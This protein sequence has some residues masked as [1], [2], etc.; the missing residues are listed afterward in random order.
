MISL[1]P[2]FLFKVYKY[3]TTNPQQFADFWD[4][5]YERLLAAKSKKTRVYHNP[6]A[7]RYLA[8]PTLKAPNV[9][10][11]NKQ[12]SREA[13]YY[14]FNSGRNLSFH[15]GLLEI[16]QMSEVISPT[17]LQ[18]MTSIS[19]TD[20]GHDQVIQ[21][22]EGSQQSLPSSWN[23]YMRLLTQLG[24]GLSTNGHRLK[25]LTID[26]SR[27]KKLG[28]HMIQCWDARHMCG[29]RD[30]FRDALA[31]FHG[32]R[33]V[34][35]V[36]LLGFNPVHAAELRK[37]MESK[38]VEFKDLPKDAR[39]I[40][41]TKALG[42]SWEG[43]SDNIMQAIADRPTNSKKKGFPYP[44][45]STPTVLL[46]NKEYSA[47]ASKIL[48]ESKK[49]LKLVLPDCTNVIKLPDM[50]KLSRFIGRETL[51]SIQGI[52]ITMSSRAWLASLDKQFFTAL[53]SKTRRLE[54]FNL[55][56]SDS[57]EYQQY[58]VYPD[59]D[60]HQNFGQRLAQ[61]HGL[62]VV[63]FEGTLPICY[64]D[65]LA[66]VMTMPRRSRATRPKMKCLSRGSVVD[67]DDGIHRV[68]E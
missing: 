40:I 29:F 30:Q 57:E 66:T 63:K 42:L 13:S 10:L 62:K 39:N 35:H 44:I 21:I 43:I 54:S 7:Y 28:E 4:H 17:I 6:G 46:L 16:A 31:T 64:T 38:P 58:P 60:L 37:R 32:V 9:F 22:Q 15:H 61:L 19:I 53:S 36:E 65:P 49:M 3:A 59:G 51:K 33:C 2:T 34:G 1:T 12:I 68:A 14:F 24:T 47:E 56:F 5:F 41:F 45:L 23:G 26:F 52:E 8:P 50:P 48:K 25:N 67:I 27:D 55:S 20:A 11:V 18:S